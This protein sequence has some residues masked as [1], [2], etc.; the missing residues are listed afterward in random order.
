MGFIANITFALAA[1]LCCCA[2][3]LYIYR[4][5]RHKER[6]TRLRHAFLYGTLI[7]TSVLMGMFVQAQGS[8][9]LGGTNMF[10]LGAWALLVAY[11]L[12]ELISRTET[13]GAFILPPVLVALCI[14]WFPSLA[15]V[16]PGAAAAGEVYAQWPVLVVHVGAFIVSAVFFLIGGAAAIMLLVQSR[17]LKRHRAGLMGPGGP[18][19]SALQRVGSRAI[20]IGMPFLTLGLLLGVSY[21]LT[22][23]SLVIM[24]GNTAPFFSARVVMSS[25]LWS[26]YAIYLIL[27]YLVN[28]SWRVTAWIAIV[29]AVG[30]AV[31][32]VMSATLPMLNG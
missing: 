32:S 14:A 10:M 28:T 11:T 21:G 4:L 6:Y 16:A 30:T 18:S 9:V 2:L 27:T 15:P 17:Q 20:A 3:A 31:L 23:G 1:A 12:F 24:S 29:G 26:C 25:L 7:T 8:R 19:L 22:T 13:Y 5:A